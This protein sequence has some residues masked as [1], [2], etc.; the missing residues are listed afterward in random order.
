M[1]V[2]PVGI[3]AIGFSGGTIVEMARLLNSDRLRQA[4][5]DHP[6]ADLAALLSDE[7]YR[8]VLGEGHPG[9]DRNRFTKVEVEQKEF[10]RPAW[11]WVSNL[12]ESKGGAS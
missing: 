9:L 1:T 4:M 10:R 8:Y 5:S 12:R 11:L 3:A 2:G 7:L 6:D